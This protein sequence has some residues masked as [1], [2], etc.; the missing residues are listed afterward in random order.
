MGASGAANKE[1]NTELTFG[2]DSQDWFTA[3]VLSFISIS[4]KRNSWD[5]THENLG[6]VPL[7]LRAHAACIK[8][9]WQHYF[10]AEQLDALLSHMRFPLGSSV[11]CTLRNSKTRSVL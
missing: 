9:G 2:K 11:K 7:P 10:L 1:A 6:C 3:I 4:R 8:I 5:E